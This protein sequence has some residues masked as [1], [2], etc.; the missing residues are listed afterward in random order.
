MNLTAARISLYYCLILSEIDDA[1]R[2]HAL[3]YMWRDILLRT[4]L[5]RYIELL[6]KNDLL[7]YRD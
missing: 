3:E 5:S 6:D 1:G 7:C 2:V 4:K